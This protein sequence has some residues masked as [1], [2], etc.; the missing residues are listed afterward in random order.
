M[1]FNKKRIVKNQQRQKFA[2]GNEILASVDLLCFSTI[3]AAKEERIQ[4]FK[5]GAERL[6]EIAAR[7]RRCYQELPRAVDDTLVSRTLEETEAEAK[8]V[9]LRVKYLFASLDSFSA[10]GEIEHA[11]IVIPYIREI[12]AGCAGI[13]LPAE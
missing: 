6:S 5:T 12:V 13:N 1:T 9:A 7:I 8:Y 3:R 2:L 10:A 11:K 4:D